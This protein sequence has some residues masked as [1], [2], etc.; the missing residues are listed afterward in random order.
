MQHTQWVMNI[1]SKVNQTAELYKPHPYGSYLG[2]KLM[3]LV[4]VNNHISLIITNA[5]TRRTS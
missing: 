5:M 4:S 2:T 3:E 1:V